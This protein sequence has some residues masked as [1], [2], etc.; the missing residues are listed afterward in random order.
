M[1]SV[2]ESQTNEPFQ[3]N[4]QTQYGEPDPKILALESHI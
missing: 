4:N 1:Q 2:P 3:E